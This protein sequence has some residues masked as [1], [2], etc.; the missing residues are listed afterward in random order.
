MKSLITQ[1]PVHRRRRVSQGELAACL[2]VARPA[3]LQLDQACQNPGEPFVARA[4]GAL[5]RPPDDL[6]ST[7]DVAVLAQKTCEV[8]R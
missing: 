5:D 3:V 6:Q 8:R 1:V 4:A 2:D 7:T